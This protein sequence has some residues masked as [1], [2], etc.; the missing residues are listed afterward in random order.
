MGV[1]ADDDEGIA[2]GRP[3]RSGLAAL[4][5]RL[6]L[7]LAGALGFHRSKYQTYFTN[8]VRIDDGIPI[9]LRV[10]PRVRGAQAID[11]RIDGVQAQARD[12]VE[13]STK[14]A[15]TKAGE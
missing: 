13:L 1:F 9:G 10:I 7:F 14:C 15:D 3:R 12:G 8:H 5:T 2:G 11:R 6:L 4:G